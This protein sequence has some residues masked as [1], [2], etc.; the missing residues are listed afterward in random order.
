M[1]QSSSETINFYKSR[2]VSPFLFHFVKGKNPMSV[3]EKILKDNALKSIKHE[4]ISYTESPLRVMKNILD[5]FQTFKD[6][7][8]CSP[9]FE[10][11]GIGLKKKKM[12]ELYGA[13][14]VIYRASSDKK[15]LD[16]SLHWRFEL[17]D[18]D[19]WDFSWQREWRTE[20]KYFDLPED[21]EDVIVICKK[22]DEVEHL[23]PLTNHP[24]ISL[25]L[26]ENNH[27]SDYDAESMAYFQ[28]MTEWELEVLKDECE[29]LR[30]QYFINNK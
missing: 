30:K 5:Y 22:E 6:K 28:L 14:P 26:I 27:M 9:M 24:I 23:K 29:E 2:D 11:Y 4:C 3:L 18:F 20:G 15:E 13:R 8:G 16:T 10:P 17:L 7:P 19:N 21:D 1:K 12:F 25:E